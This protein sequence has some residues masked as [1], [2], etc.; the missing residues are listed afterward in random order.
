M[1]VDCVFGALDLRCEGTDARSRV[2]NDM[3]SVGHKHT[4]KLE[5]DALLHK[6]K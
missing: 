3:T 6:V 5:P 4:H 2:M 1:V